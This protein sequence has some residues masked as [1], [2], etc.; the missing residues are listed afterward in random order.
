MTVFN[1]FHGGQACGDHGTVTDRDWRCSYHSK[2]FHHMRHAVP[3]LYIVLMCFDSTLR[4]L[5]A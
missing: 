5:F 3:C 4:S 2:Q 1:A